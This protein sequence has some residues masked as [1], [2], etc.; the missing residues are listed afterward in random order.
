MDCVCRVMRVMNGRVFVQCRP[1]QLL[2]SVH[3]PSV[4]LHSIGGKGSALF[5]QGHNEEVLRGEVASWTGNQW[6]EARLREEW[7]VKGSGVGPADVFYRRWRAWCTAFAK[8]PTGLRNA[9]DW[10]ST[11]R[12]REEKSG[13]NG[14]PDFSPERYSARVLHGRVVGIDNM[15]SCGGYVDLHEEHGTTPAEM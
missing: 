3:Q 8:R 9:E 12:G 10:R 1:A 11:Q 2:R 15:N 6:K 4:P 13:F 14:T 7:H 5:A